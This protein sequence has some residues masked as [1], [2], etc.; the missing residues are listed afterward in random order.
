MQ[1]A[2]WKLVSFEDGVDTKMATH[3]AIADAHHV[4]YT[5][6][7]AV[8]AVATG[9]DYIKNT[10]DTMT[11]T[12]ESTAVMGFKFCGHTNRFRIASGGTYFGWFGY[13]DSEH[14]L[15]WFGGVKTDEGGGNYSGK[16]SYWISYNGGTEAVKLEIERLKIV[17]KTYL[18]LE[19]IRSGSTQA[20][21][22]AAA[23][24]VWKTSGH[25]SLPDNMLMIGV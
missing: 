7:E 24:E 17:A 18:L 8:S 11:G 19:T 13:D 2:E 16:L 4:K 23:Y 10:G 21:A 20:N 6:A 15:A 5:D 9:D 25:A 3:A 12:L 22:G 14:K 1:M